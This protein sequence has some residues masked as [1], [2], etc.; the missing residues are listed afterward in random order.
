MPSQPKFTYNAIIT[1][2][3]SGDQVVA[4]VDLGFGIKSKEMFTLKDCEAPKR[5]EPGYKKAR[6]ALQYEVMHSPVVI[7]TFPKKDSRGYTAEIWSEGLY[8]SVSVNELMLI[9]G[10]VKRVASS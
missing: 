10:H 9:K 8:S 6:E 7:A 4:I 1:N 5:S 3:V 2:V